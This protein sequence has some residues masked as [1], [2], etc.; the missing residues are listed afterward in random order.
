MVS[1]V[2]PSPPAS[3]RMGTL[4]IGFGQQPQLPYKAAA[5]FFVPF[6]H[7]PLLPAQKMR[8]FVARHSRYLA[9]SAIE[10]SYPLKNVR[11]PRQYPSRLFHASAATQVVKPYLLADIG[12]GP[13]YVSFCMLRLTLCRDHRM[14]GHPMVRPAGSPS[15]AVRQDM[16][17][18]VGQGNSRGSS[19][20]L[21]LKS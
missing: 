16:R 10:A 9:G 5:T 20:L 2:G 12:E 21:V 19:R 15:R 13:C 14:P 7:S 6:F 8:R 3:P 17:G 1:R 4:N 11:I 18:A